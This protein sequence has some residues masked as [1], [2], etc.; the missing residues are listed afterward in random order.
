MCGKSDEPRI[1][2]TV[3]VNLANELRILFEETMSSHRNNFVSLSREKIC[4]RKMLMT[5]IQDE[6][7]FFRTQNLGSKLSMTT[8][9]LHRN[10]YKIAC[11]EFVVF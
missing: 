3:M 2:P 7:C 8:F 11:V 4:R 10:C 9:S 6:I 5:V 1:E